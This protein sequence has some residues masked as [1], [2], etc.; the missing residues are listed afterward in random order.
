MNELRKEVANHDQELQDLNIKLAI[1]DEITSPKFA[2]RGKYKKRHIRY[3][4][5][6]VPRAEWRVLCG[7]RYGK[8]V[9]ERRGKIPDDLPDLQKCGTCFDLDAEDE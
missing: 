8:S 1:M 7:W 2:I 5:H 6:E 4:Y 9:F 3:Q